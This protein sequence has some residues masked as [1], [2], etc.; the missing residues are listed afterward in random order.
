MRVP[1]LHIDVEPT[2]RAEV[3]GHRLAF[4]GLRLLRKGV[5]VEYDVDPPLA[6][7]MGHGPRIVRLVVTDDT[8][9]VPY[10]TAWED[11][12]WPEHGPGRTTTRLERRPAP[13][14]TC[15]HVAVLPAHTDLP[16]APGPASVALRAIA[17]FD[18]PLPAAHG[19]PWAAATP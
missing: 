12:R 11:F 2:V 17:T 1:R 4:V 8:S 18:V 5:I 10:V 15:L 16:A 7:G 3:D 13:E 14:A 9:T 6:E 19:L